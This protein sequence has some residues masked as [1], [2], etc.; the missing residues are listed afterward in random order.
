MTVDLPV[1]PQGGYEVTAFEVL[2]GVVYPRRLVYSVA[3]DGWRLHLVFQ[4][5]PWVNGW[6]PLELPDTWYATRAAAL[7]ELEA[8]LRAQVQLHESALTIA[9]KQLAQVQTDLDI[10]EHPA[11]AS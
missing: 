9:R 3:T 6:S 5:V 10:E 11:P 1:K 2:D 8:R 4:S 7:T